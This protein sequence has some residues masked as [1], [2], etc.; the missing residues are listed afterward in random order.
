M[1]TFRELYCER[2]GVAFDKFE[3]HLVWR[4]LH[5]QARPFFWLRGLNA[6]Y[7]SADFEFVRGVGELRSRREFRNEAA[8]FHY[9]PANRGFF[10][11]ILR[12]RVSSHRLQTL[13]EREINSATTAAPF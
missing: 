7:Y 2:Y 13:F 6:D 9:H 4:A 3:R 12:M 8:E 11:T 1:K 10:R 5:W